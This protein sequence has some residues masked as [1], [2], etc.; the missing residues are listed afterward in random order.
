[1]GLDAGWVTDLPLPRTLALR[2]LGNGV[3]PQQAAVALAVLLCPHRWAH[4]RPSPAGERAAITGPV[5]VPA[6]R[7]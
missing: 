7:A 4:E 6:D 5:P 1:M 2:M 3:V